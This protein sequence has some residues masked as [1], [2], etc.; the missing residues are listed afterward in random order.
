M[1]MVIDD[2]SG[3]LGCTWKRAGIHDFSVSRINR[4]AVSLESGL[5]RDL[6]GKCP[7]SKATVWWA[8]AEDGFT[9]DMLTDKQRAVVARIQAEP[10]SLMLT[11]EEAAAYE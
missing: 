11:P 8:I 4:L 10:E 7:S 3:E 6:C 1:S 5:A 2:R 9:T